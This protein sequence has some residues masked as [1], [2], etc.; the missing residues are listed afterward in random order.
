M[1][2][3]CRC[4]APAGR[5]GN[6]G[7]GEKM[8]RKCAIAAGAAI[9][10]L[11]I[12]PTASAALLT[13]DD[14]TLPGD[15]IQIVN[16]VGDS[17]NVNGPPPANE[18]VTNAID[19]TTNKYLNFV[20]YGS[21]F[22]VSPS[23]GPSIVR[24][25]RIYSANDAAGR[26]PASFIL[27]GAQSANGPFTVIYGS[28]ITLPGGGDGRNPTGLPLDPNTQDF[29]AVLFPNTTQYNSYRVT[30]PTLRDPADVGMQIA[31]VELLGTI[32]PEPASLGLLGLG[33]VGLLRRR[34]A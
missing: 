13:L 15:P 11:S 26:D 7:M 3:L 31:E 5:V 28:N 22:I 14:V 21:G 23:Q 8:L 17:D 6:Q 12:A 24:G 19:N 27:E 1:E 20:D 34:R 33:M 25:I 29:A 2:D 32:I 18:G 9:G 30:F 10:F 4:R 16:G